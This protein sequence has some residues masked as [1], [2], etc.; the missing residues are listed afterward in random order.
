MKS[1]VLEMRDVSLK[2]RRMPVLEG[3]NLELAQGGHHRAER[4]R[5]DRSPERHPRPAD[6]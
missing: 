5:Q 6:T 1:P 2:L 3:V 4:R